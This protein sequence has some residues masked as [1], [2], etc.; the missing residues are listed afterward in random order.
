M[1]KKELKY[2]GYAP[3]EITEAGDAFITKNLGAKNRWE[4]AMSD[5]V[6]I[7]NKGWSFKLEPIQEGVRCV[8]CNME[9]CYGGGEQVYVS[10]EADDI[11]TATFV[12]FWK[13]SEAVNFL[14]DL[15]VQN[16]RAKGK[17]R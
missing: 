9:D 13:L 4:V 7:L 2:A 14:P 12:Q 10:S 16:N 8:S 5:V 17:Y 6:T 3:V 1:A 11:L 15:P